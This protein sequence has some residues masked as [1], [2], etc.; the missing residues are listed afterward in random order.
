[1]LALN[2]TASFLSS[3]FRVVTFSVAMYSFLTLIYNTVAGL[4]ILYRA[5]AASPFMVTS[6]PM[7]TLPGSTLRRDFFQWPMQ[8]PIRK[9]LY[10]NQ[11]SLTNGY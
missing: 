9:C 6:S 1:M 3:C 7:R 11:V 10:E 2:F 8:V 4:I 5:L